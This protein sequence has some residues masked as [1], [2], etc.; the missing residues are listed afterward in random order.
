MFNKT[1]YLLTA[2]IVM[3]GCS[4]SNTSAPVVRKAG[5]FTS[6]TIPVFS[7][8]WVDGKVQL[9]TKTKR[10]CGAFA[11]NILPATYDKDFT[12]DIEGDRDMF[13]HFSRAD[14]QLVCDEVGIF[15]AKAG[16]EYTLNLV[17]KNKQC[18]ISLI[19]KTPAGNQNKIQTYQAYLSIVDGIKVCTN[20][21]RLY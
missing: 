8:Q 17:T 11:K 21:D 20:K 14:G 19:E 4:S 10:D 2:T 16:N 15:Y 13:F 18:E 6:I 7:D 12:S 1:L 5:S 3:A 9:A